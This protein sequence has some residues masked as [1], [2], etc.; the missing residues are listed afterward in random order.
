MSLH[1]AKHSWWCMLVLDGIRVPKHHWQFYQRAKC[2]NER[3]FSFT[4]NTNKSTGTCPPPVPHIFQRVKCDIQKLQQQKCVHCA[5]G[6]TDTCNT[7]S[8]FARATKEKQALVTIYYLDIRRRRW[9]IMK[10][11]S[12]SYMHTS[13][14][15]ICI[16]AKINNHSQ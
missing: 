16:H 3:K 12:C 10:Q 11:K 1:S 13:Y 7:H 5:N 4:H 2:S 8:I 9:D 14:L 15:Y 6:H